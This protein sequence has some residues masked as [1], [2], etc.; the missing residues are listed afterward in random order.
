MAKELKSRSGKSK[1]SAVSLDDCLAENRAVAEEKPPSQ[2]NGSAGDTR[3]LSHSE[4]TLTNDCKMCNT[5]LQIH[6]ARTVLAVELMPR[7]A[8]LKQEKLIF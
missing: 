3:A 4:S 6:K 5:N 1:S 2:M 8:V 7:A